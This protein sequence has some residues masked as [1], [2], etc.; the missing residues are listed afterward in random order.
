[1]KTDYEKI[2]EKL[3]IG[4]STL[5]QW[6]KT[7]PELYDFIINSFHITE[8]GNNKKTDI[9]KELCKYLEDLTQEELEL[10]YHEIKARALRK[11]IG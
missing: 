11:K 6:K 4:I 7:R 1:M 8:N 3:K 9:K 10:Y 5:Y 2:A